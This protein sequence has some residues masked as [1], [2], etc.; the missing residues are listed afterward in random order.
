MKLEKTRHFRIDENL[1][2]KLLII[3]SSTNKNPSQ[4]IRDLIKKERTW[5][6]IEESTSR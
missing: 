4:A 3:C 6:Q 1:D 2:K 5:E